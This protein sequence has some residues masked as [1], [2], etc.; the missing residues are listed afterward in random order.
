MNELSKEDL[1]FALSLRYRRLKRN[2]DFFGSDSSEEL[3]WGKIFLHLFGEF[4]STYRYRINMNFENFQADL[5]Q[6]YMPKAGQII[7]IERDRKFNITGNEYNFKRE[8]LLVAKKS[9]T[10]AFHDEGIL[11]YYGNDV[12]FDEVLEIKQIAD[13]NWL[14]PPRKGNVYMITGQG[15]GMDITPFELPKCELDIENNYNEDFCD[16]DRVI[17]EALNNDHK[18]GLILLHG[19]YGT[20]KTYY[21]RHLMWAIE[22]RDFIYMPNYLVNELS[23]PDFIPFIAK[24]KNSVLILED[25]ENILVSREQG[26]LNSTAISTMLSLGD[27]LLGDALSIKA[28]CT[29]NADLKKID[30][31]IL[32]KGRLIARYEFKELE[33]HKA[34]NLLFNLGKDVVINKPM[35]LAEIYNIDEMS[36]E[37]QKLK[38][39]GFGIN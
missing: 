25:C 7:K 14:P 3:H 27:G 31:A 35:S 20:G 39:V 15:P 5:V 22:N 24:H 8:Y 36:F 28:I 12:C 32:R 34:Q 2:S 9:L 23:S 29:F 13:K 37:D 16:I 6:K 4:F 18:N 17:K 10:I 21:I 19:K 38:R 26:N 33:L 30:D 1:E 11:V